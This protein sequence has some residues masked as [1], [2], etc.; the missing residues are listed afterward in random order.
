MEFAANMKFFV[1]KTIKCNVYSRLEV[2][3]GDVHI[4]TFIDILIANQSKIWFSDSP[5]TNSFVAL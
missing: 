3:T 4:A 2:W 1:R 5:A